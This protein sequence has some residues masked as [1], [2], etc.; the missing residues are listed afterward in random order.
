MHYSASMFA[1][2]I[3]YVAQGV[4]SR[5]ALLVVL[6]LGVD[7]ALFAQDP[8]HDRVRAPG[9]ASGCS[10]GE[11]A[12]S[13]QKR[14]SGSCP[15]PNQ[16]D[17][18]TTL[19]TD[20]DSQF[21]GW[22]PW[23]DGRAYGMRAVTKVP[24]TTCSISATSRTM[25]LGEASSF[26]NGDGIVCRGAGAALNLSTP[27]APTVVAENASGP[28][29]TGNSV[30]NSSGATRYQYCVVAVK[31]DGSFTPC[32]ATASIDNGPATLGPQATLN[33]TS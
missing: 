7:N 2:L 6:L 30:P 28:T 1:R 9:G 26:R 8:L 32:S 24:T 18:K 10:P 23:I 25:T 20:K 14:S 16:T 29:G 31:Q 19:A 33:I 15:G 4:A 27:R 13:V 21:E 17:N 5:I 22:S 11:D 12:N 3:R